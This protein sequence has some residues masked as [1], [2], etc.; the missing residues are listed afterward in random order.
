MILVIQV[1]N[2]RKVNQSCSLSRDEDCVDFS[3]GC[4]DHDVFRR[5]HTTAGG[6]RVRGS[7][8]SSSTPNDFQSS[9]HKGDLAFPQIACHA[10]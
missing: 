4:S 3:M 5:E 7:A 9:S 10:L 1:R 8:V 2:Q 6:G